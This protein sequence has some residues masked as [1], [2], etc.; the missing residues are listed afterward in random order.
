MSES[1]ALRTRSFPLGAAVTL[2]ELDAD[3]APVLAQ[4]RAV[5]PVSWV[6]ALGAWLITSRALAVEAMRD[7]ETFTVDDPRFS[8]AAV[9]GT[10]MLSLDGAEHE[11]HR[12]PFG[13]AFRPNMVR[14]QFEEYLVSEA[15]RLV[16]AVVASEGGDLRT[17]LAG[18]LAVNTIVQFLGLE[19]VRADDVLHWYA[20]ISD[21][22]VGIASGVDIPASCKAVVAD[23]AGRVEQTIA[24]GAD[25]LLSHL[26]AD[27]RLS[28]EELVTETVVVMF[29]A[30]ETSEG[31]TANAL[32]H[33][34]VD[35]DVTERVR[36][37]RSLVADVVEE[38]LRLEPAAAVVDR[39][40]TRSVDFGGALIAERDLVEISLLGANRDPAV[41]ERP[42]DF[43]I[44]RPNVRQ[45]V[46][47][48]Q[49][50]HGCLGLH[51][52]RLETVAAINA[53]L[54]AGLVLDA[55]AT[56]CPSGLIFRKPSSVAVTVD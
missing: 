47:F 48:V 29:G 45:H 11:R 54:D 12:A 28:A 26:A 9:L 13:P 52:A 27:G 14:Q 23:V 33:L 2:A 15:H 51:L 30:I 24:N 4:L 5:E 34:L 38:S 53:V 41:F 37:D 42:D 6:P 21:A 36:A 55:A 16:S 10:S 44:D 32:R 35:P 39:Y 1:S 25:H 40:A 7:A 50:P 22:I 31:M 18:P 49:G 8:T 19:T 46:S 20:E 17:Q 3:P 43:V 56:T